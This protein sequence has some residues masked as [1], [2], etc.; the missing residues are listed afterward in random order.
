[1]T[2]PKV[3]IDNNLTVYLGGG[4]NSIVLTSKD[5]TESL[6]VDTKWFQSAKRLRAEIKAPKITIINTH[7]HMDHARGNKL[8]PSAFV[9]SGETNWKQWDIDTGHSN[10]PD[11]ILKPADQLSLQIDDETIQVI[12]MGNA[13]SVNDLIVYFTKRRLLAVGD[14]VWVDMHP[15]LLDSNGNVAVWR[16]ILD[17]LE[18]DF[19]IDKVVPGHGPICDK[20]SIT[21][22][23]E[24]FS[25]IANAI[26][27]PSKLSKLKSNYRSYKAFPIFAGFGR[28]VS[29]MTKEMNVNLRQNRLSEKRKTT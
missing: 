16:R 29:R 12:A 26:K 27:N 15:I 25:S 3:E 7:F 24:Y 11:A 28:T 17:K 1:M 14:L 10:R 6:V 9:I 21:K 18:S 22:M 4:C 23:S 20:N 13:H 5:S 19:E 8:Y 2:Q